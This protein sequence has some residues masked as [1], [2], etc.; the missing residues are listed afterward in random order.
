M[1]CCAGQPVFF[2]PIY[3]LFKHIRSIMVESKDETG[4]DLN[5]LR[6]K[7]FHSPG[8]I[9]RKRR[10]LSCIGKVI[11]D[12]RIQTDKNSCTTG[13]RHLANQRR[14]VRYINGYSRAPNFVYFVK[15]LTEFS[16]IVSVGTQVV[17]R[18]HPIGFI[19]V[20]KLCCNLLGVP[21][22]IWHD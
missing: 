11:P 14:I 1:K 6:M 2:Q 8:V 16:E 17:V 13:K 5:P 22:L 4:V 9:L 19:T 20:T 3:G 15:F 18:K 12:E 7:Y 10:L 21:H